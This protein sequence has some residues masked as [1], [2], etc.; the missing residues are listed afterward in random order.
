MKRS[1]LN[2]EALELLEPDWNQIPLWVE[3]LTLVAIRLGQV[4]LH[5][6]AP[7][8]DI[9]ISEG[10]TAAGKSYFRVRDRLNGDSITPHA[11]GPYRLFESEDDLR[12]WLEQ[13]YY[14]PSIRRSK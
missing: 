10:T 11:P 12:A 8:D 14:Q 9:A 6:L 4:L 13:R 1:D 3:T 7:E 5:I 2:Y